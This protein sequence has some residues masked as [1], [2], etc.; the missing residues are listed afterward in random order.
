MIYE[1]LS[2]K[3]L[4]FVGCDEFFNDILECLPARG[5]VLK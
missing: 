5:Q 4:F 3:F 1:K 2:L